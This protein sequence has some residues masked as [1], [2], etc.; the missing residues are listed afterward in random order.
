MDEHIP[1]DT[2]GTLCDLDTPLEKI[3]GDSITFTMKEPQAA[4]PE[5]GEFIVSPKYK[6]EKKKPKF[7]QPIDS[8]KVSVTELPPQEKKKS[9]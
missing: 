7:I 3:V 9:H 6:S 4:V 8:P 2:N 1:E 5:N